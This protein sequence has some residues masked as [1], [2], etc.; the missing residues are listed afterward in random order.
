M[1]TVVTDTE[2]R[3]AVG[4]VKAGVVRVG[5]AAVGVAAEG[6]AVTIGLESRAICKI[7][8][9]GKMHKLKTV[10]CRAIPDKRTLCTVKIQ[11]AKCTSNAN[12]GR[13]S[14]NCVR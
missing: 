14:D 4:V 3:E 2:V 9:A 1:V 12:G 6:V 5:E 7:S 10:E 11:S 8:E 13:Q